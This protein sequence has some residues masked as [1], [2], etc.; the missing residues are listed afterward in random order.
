V[1]AAG[2]AATAMADEPPAPLELP[3][4]FLHAVSRGGVLSATSVLLSV[5]FTSH[6][7]YM[8]GPRR[9]RVR[10]VTSPPA[11][12]TF[13]V[14]I[15]YGWAERPARS[16]EICDILHAVG[17]TACAPGSEAPELAALAHLPCW[18]PPAGG[19]PTYGCVCD[20]PGCGACL[21][22]VFVLSSAFLLPP[23]SAR[24]PM[25]LYCGAYNGLLSIT[26][27]TADFL[28]LP[29]PACVTVSP[30]VIVPGEVDSEAG[31]AAWHASTA[32]QAEAGSV[33]LRRTIRLARA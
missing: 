12:A 7:A 4:A 25:R 16:A 23:P 2:V 31:R 22:I 33:R 1:K 15:H 26:S 8:R 9:A 14:A 24:L 10:R 19:A 18:A 30:V 11:P 29:L 27:S 21:P 3:H 6:M 5:E 17:V 32:A 13:S 28:K 20:T